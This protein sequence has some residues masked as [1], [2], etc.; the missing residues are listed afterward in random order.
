MKI[1]PDTFDVLVVGTGLVNSI[2]AASVAVRG[3]TVLQIDPSDHYG[4]RWATVSYDTIVDRAAAIG[5]DVCTVGSVDTSTD[6][7]CFLFDLNPKMAYADGP[8]ISLLLESG[9]HNYTEFSLAKLVVWSSDAN[10]FVP[11]AASRAEIFRDTSLTLKQK[12]TLMKMIRDISTLGND[13]NQNFVSVLQSIYAFDRDLTDRVVHGVLLQH[14]SPCGMTLD[15]ASYLLN[16]Y[17]RSSGKYGKNSSPFLLPLHGGGEMPQAFCRAA[18]VKGAIQCLRCGVSSLQE[19]ESGEFNVLLTSDQTI[20]AQ[21]ILASPHLLPSLAAK[22]QESCAMFMCFAIVQGK[23]FPEERQCLAAYPR[24]SSRGAVIWMLQRDDS[25]GCCP[26]GFSCL[27]VWCLVDDADLS[28]TPL[29]EFK[30]LLTTHLDCSSIFKGEDSKGNAKV[31]SACFVRFEHEHLKSSPYKNLAW[32]SDLI[33]DM[34]YVNILDESKRCFDIIC[35]GE[36][37]PFDQPLPQNHQDG[38]PTDEN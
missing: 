18:A 32:C 1:E 3:K 14:S 5:R 2:I 33:E 29:T 12:N 37:F 27:Q 16:L 22:G 17:G 38:R 26:D 15:S 9:A 30:D 7:T 31:L 21:K 20:H 25:S 13:V 24:P 36:T 8:L 23:I 4:E 11:I 19:T 28:T 35:P 34:T 6:M 10:A